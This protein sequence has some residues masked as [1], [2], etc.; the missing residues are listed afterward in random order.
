MEACWLVTPVQTNDPTPFP[1]HLPPILPVSKPILLLPFFFLKIFS[2]SL[3]HGLWDFSSPTY[4]NP[5][6]KGEPGSECVGS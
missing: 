1:N 4:L 2:S 3:P 5:G 6:E